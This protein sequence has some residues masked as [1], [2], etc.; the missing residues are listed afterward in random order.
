MRPDNVPDVVSDPVFTSDIEVK[1]RKPLQVQRVRYIS[2]I[3]SEQSNRKSNQ[4]ILTVSFVLLVLTT[5][6]V[7]QTVLLTLTVSMMGGKSGS[8]G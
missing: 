1:G 7:G 2:D 6:S 8:D 5:E 4:S 3:C